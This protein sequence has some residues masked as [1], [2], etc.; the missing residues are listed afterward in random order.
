[1]LS[2][3]SS[4]K[5]KGKKSGGKE[6]TKNIKLNTSAEELPEVSTAQVGSI[7][8]AYLSTISNWIASIIHSCIFKMLILMP[9]QLQ[10][11]VNL[12]CVTCN[13][14]FPSRNKLFDHLKTTGH[15]SALSSAAQGSTSRGKKDKKKNR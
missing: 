2:R 8:M 10:K 12:H 11:E 13:K 1:M 3:G 5:Q 15:A 4:G 6:K 7:F 14:E 9:I